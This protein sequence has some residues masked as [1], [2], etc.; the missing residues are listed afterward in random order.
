MKEKPSIAAYFAIISFPFVVG[1]CAAILPDVS[2]VWLEIWI[3]SLFLLICWIG[4]GHF[5]GHFYRLSHRYLFSIVSVNLGA[6]Y[7]LVLAWRISGEAVWLGVVFAVLFVASIIL[8]YKH[9]ATVCKLFNMD[10]KNGKPKSQKDGN[11]RW[12]GIL[13]IAGSIV[14]VTGGGAATGLPTLVLFICTMIIS[15]TFST[16]YYQ[17]EVMA[18]SQEDSNPLP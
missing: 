12:I 18:E 8:G 9:R 11:L 4:Y 1:G 15:T 16:I 17:V 7:A 2:T 5:F 14:S 6:F 3:L 13:F 10:I